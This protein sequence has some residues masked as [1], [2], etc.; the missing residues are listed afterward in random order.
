V[1]GDD[2]EIWWCVQ[3]SD[4]VREMNVF[5]YICKEMDFL[6]VL[7]RKIEIEM[8]VVARIMRRG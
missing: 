2:D 4:C 3:A 6:C 8:L 5:I 7:V 1:D